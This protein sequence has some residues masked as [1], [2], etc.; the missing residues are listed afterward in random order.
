MRFPSGNQWAQLWLMLS[1]VR[2]LG[3]PA[4]VGSSLELRG[5]FLGLRDRP[6]SVGRQALPRRLRRAGRRVSHRFCECR[7]RRSSRRTWNNR[8]HRRRLLRQTA[9][10]CHRRKDRR[11]RC[12]RARRVRAAWDRRRSTAE[13][14]AA[15]G[16]ADQQHASVFGD[17]EQHERA[18][19]A[20]DD[21]LFAV[22]RSG[23]ESAIRARLAGGEPDLFA[24][25][26][27]RQTLNREPLR[28]REFSCCRRDR[29]RRASRCRRLA[30][31]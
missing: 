11:D 22:E 29:R 5:R 9:E 2:S 8:A 18:G 30:A 12:N 1:L 3:S 20:G 10:S 7:R 17:V 6:F 15:P 16:G 23:V 25:G 26:R 4:P 21:A 27:P 31:G 24:I 28:R 19:Q 13:Q 14:F